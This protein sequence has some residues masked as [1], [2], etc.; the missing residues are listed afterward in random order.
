MRHEIIDASQLELTIL[1]K[2]G[3]LFN[4]KA[5]FSRM[6]SAGT[7]YANGI[8]RDKFTVRMEG[9]PWSGTRSL[10]R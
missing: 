5:A 9:N 3:A 1:P 10:W 4:G 7:G 8:P 2:S 6:V